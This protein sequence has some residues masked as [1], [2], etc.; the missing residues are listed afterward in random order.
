MLLHAHIHAATV[1]SQNCAGLGNPEVKRQ[2]GPALMVLIIVLW[3]P[4]G[5]EGLSA[6]P[7]LLKCLLEPGPGLWGLESPP[8]LWDP[9]RE[10]VP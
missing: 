10:L 1:G 2:T 8:V 6:L 7:G 5:N 4:H 3:L 9:L